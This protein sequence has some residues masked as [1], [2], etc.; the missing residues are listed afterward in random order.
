MC[1]YGHGG[2]ST[3]NININHCISKGHLIG[4]NC[5]GICAGGDVN[6]TISTNTGII[7]GCIGN[8]NNNDLLS[9]TG[10]SGTV[11]LIYNIKHCISHGNM[12]GNNCGFICG[13]GTSS[14]VGIAGCIGNGNN[15]QVGRGIFNL[16]ISCNIEHCQSKG[17]L[18][19]GN[20]CGG[21]CA[22]GDNSGCI[23]N[24]NSNNSILNNNTSTISVKFYKCKVNV[25]VKNMEINYGGICGGGDNTTAIGSNNISFGCIGNF[26]T[27]ITSDISTPFVLNVTVEE[28]KVKNLYILSNNSGGIF[29][30]GQFNPQT[31]TT[32]YGACIGCGNTTN[33][34][35]NSINVS[36][37]K[38]VIVTGISGHGSGGICARYI[39]QPLYSQPNEID[40]FLTIN[41]CAIRGH[42]IKSTSAGI[43]AGYVDNSCS[44]HISNCYTTGKVLHK[45]YPFVGQG[46][47]I[48][49]NAI[50]VTDSYASGIRK[51]KHIHGVIFSH[52]YTK[53]NLHKIIGKLDHLSKH[54]WK[55][56]E[57]KPPVLTAIGL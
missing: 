44:T 27:L 56:R 20:N 35:I 12:K 30:G 1:G 17:L 55:A 39:G 57:H 50:K 29:G 15:V 48:T 2:I 31:S 43:L 13:G 6:N 26:N 47:T 14:S 16:Y 19:G 21:I 4:C 38:S 53:H 41:R 10:Q 11:T 18:I 34:S 7:A 28:C 8:G 24:G 49:T 40:I 3:L 22:G 51:N 36:V 45:A 52:I 33:S 25:T 54:F 32:G 5:G 42:H 46:N 37:L 23:G 9:S